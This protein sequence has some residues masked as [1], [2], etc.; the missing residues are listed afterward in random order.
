M[1]TS[2]SKKFKTNYK[3]YIFLISGITLVGNIGKEKGSIWWPLIGCYLITP[4][5]IM[6]YTSFLLTTLLG[7]IAFQIFAKTWRRQIRDPPGLC[8]RFFIITICISLYISLWGAYIYFNLKI[9]TK[10]GDKIKFR[11]AAGNFIKSPAFQEFSKNLK[12]LWI[13]LLEHGFG[14]TF[15][16]LIER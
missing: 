10:D 15:Q 1:N 4:F 7:I 2:E 13:H 9:T 3:F 16:Q 12:N 8:K 14:S 5:H 6:G 11:D